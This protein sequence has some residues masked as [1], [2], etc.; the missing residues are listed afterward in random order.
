MTFVLDALGRPIL[1]IF[2][3]ADFCELIELLREMLLFGFAF[4]VL[5]WSSVVSVSC[6]GLCVWCGGGKSKW[7]SGVESI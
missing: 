6:V 3:G 1:L 2:T 5:S 7:I 4:S